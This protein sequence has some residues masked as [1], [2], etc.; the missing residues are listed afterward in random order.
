MTEIINKNDLMIE[1]KK[2]SKAHA[3][4]MHEVVEIGAVSTLTLGYGGSAD[5][6]LY[7]QAW[8]Y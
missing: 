5:E 6:G 8:K 2:I 1:I 3:N 4:G 7:K